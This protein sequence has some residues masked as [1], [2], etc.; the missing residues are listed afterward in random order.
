[1][2]DQVQTHRGVGEKESAGVL[3]VRADP[4]DLGREVD[5]DVGPRIV[6]H[7]HDIRLAGEVVVFAAGHE[8]R[9]ALHT[10]TP[11]GFD[12]KSP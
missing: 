11:E 4:A 10:A 2:L 7:P 9:I 6:V 5:D 8:D 1:M 12:H 3:A